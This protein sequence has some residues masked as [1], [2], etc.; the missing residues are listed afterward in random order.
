MAVAGTACLVHA[1]DN[2][3][4]KNFYNIIFERF[5]K[6]NNQVDH[7]ISAEIIEGT[8]KNGHPYKAVQFSIMTDEGEYR[9][10]LC[11]PTPLEVNLVE[12]A[13]TSIDSQPF[14]N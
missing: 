12:K 8:T 6:M 3:L 9:S 14:E 13:I 5:C 4:Y 11:F 7:Y 1:T 10:P 2:H